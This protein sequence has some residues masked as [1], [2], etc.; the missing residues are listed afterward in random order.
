[1]S[2]RKSRFLW[3]EHGRMEQEAT[4]SRRVDELRHQLES[5]CRE[6]QDWVAEATGARAMELRAVERATTAERG[7]EAAKVCQ[8]ETEAGLWTSLANTEAALQEALAALEPERATLERVQKA[9][10][11]E[12]RAQSE[13]D[14]EVLALQGQVMGMEDASG[15][16]HK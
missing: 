4:M 12:Q 7:L 3:E 1:M 6:S 15:W 16:L 10:E 5:A 9:L 14:Q 11:V 13:V 2:I 8:A